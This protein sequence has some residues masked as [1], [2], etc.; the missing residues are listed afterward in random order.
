MS[1]DIPTLRALLATATPGP[2]QFCKASPDVGCQC[3]LVWSMACDRVVFVARREDEDG[4]I[5]HEQ[6]VANARLVAAL[7]N[8]VPEL[9]D[10]LESLGGILEALVDRLTAEEAAEVAR[11]MARWAIGRRRS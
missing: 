7:R 8:E 6:M 4:S 5:P 10:T 2:W 9:L 3:G 1:A 11:E